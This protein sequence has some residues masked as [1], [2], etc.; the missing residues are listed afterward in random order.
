M[1]NSQKRTLSQYSDEEVR[2]L[3]EDNGNSSDK[4]ASLVGC[5]PSTFRDRMRLLNDPNYVDEK[6]KKNAVAFLMEE[7]EARGID[8]RQ[9]NI[10]QATVKT[11]KGTWDTMYKNAQKEGV[12][13]PMKRDRRTVQIQF[14][15]KFEEGPQWPVIQQPAPK[16]IKYISQ[17]K[18]LA[19]IFTKRVFIIPD[20]Q[21]GYYRNINTMELT[22]FHDLQAITVMLKMLKEY[23]PDTVV[24]LGDFL[25]C[26][27]LS[28]YLQV[29]EFQLTLQ[30]SL[31]YA[32][33]LLCQV[34]SIVGPKCKIE[35]IE[36]N[37]ERRL[38]EFIARNALAA[39]GLRRAASVP[40]AWPV[41]SIPHLL[42][43]DE[44]SIG[45]SATYPGGQFWLTPKLVCTHQPPSKKT[46]LRASVIHGHT[47]HYRVD[48][49][50]V[51]YMDGIE[52]YHVY[53]IPGLMHVEDVAEPQPLVRSQTPSAGTRMNWTQGVATVDI[54]TDNVFKVQHHPIANGEGIFGTKVFTSW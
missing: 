7:L 54:L 33:E 15:P 36:G 29:S 37:H 34:R 19:S 53:S 24:I 27:S 40:D 17:G 13:L 6:D 25:D 49:H 11:D 5:G 1:L 9:V 28:K 20:A 35:Y 52:S 8:P 42:R 23:K 41:L 38:S 50:S 47:P 10:K 46:D 30:P 14:S 26:A 2:V 21:I 16:N 43:L 32:H 18:E 51:H 22:P 4:A 12:K 3:Y 31:E 45:Y 39:Y 48:G 44:L